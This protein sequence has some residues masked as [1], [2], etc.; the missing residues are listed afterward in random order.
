MAA[1]R[2][3]YTKILYF[4]TI[5]SFL[6]GNE[7]TNGDRIRKMTNEELASFIFNAI[8]DTEWNENGNNNYEDDWREWIDAPYFNK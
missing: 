8:E 5:K 6:E 3:S 1:S 4:D 2:T 7:M